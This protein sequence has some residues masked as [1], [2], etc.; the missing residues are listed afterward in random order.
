[1]PSSASNKATNTLAELSSQIANAVESAAGSVVAIHAR[2]RIP[3]SG[4]V[5]RAGLVVSAAHTVRSDGRVNLTLPNGDRG[6]AEVIGCDAATD[7]VALRLHDGST[8]AVARAPAESE[9]VGS[10]VVAVGRPGPRVSA[11]FGMVSAVRDSWRTAHGTRVERVLR[12]DLSVYDGFSGG[13]LVDAAG[14]AIGIDN[15]A[16]ARGA[17]LALTGATIDRVLDELLERGHVRRPFIGVAVHPV[18]LGKALAERHGLKGEQVL[19]VV[20][21]GDDTPAS[22]AG[23]SLGDVLLDAGGKA[24]AHPTD[25]LDAL[26]TVRDG[27]AVKLTVLRGGR[28]ETI[29]VTPVD[30]RDEEAA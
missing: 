13:A 28:V 12:L 1:M 8:P 15:S 18:A 25:L 7:L 27:D 17:P 20:S 23:L 19:L 24:L 3:S 5:W 30:R 11:A 10:L 26:A 6:S 21:V 16:L 29:A 2:Q 4:V 22:R 9:R 14:R